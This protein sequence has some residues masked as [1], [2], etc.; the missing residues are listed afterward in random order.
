MQQI[1]VFIHN[2]TNKRF[3]ALGFTVCKP[4]EQTIITFMSLISTLRLEPSENIGT[5]TTTNSSHSE[6]GG[7]WRGGWAVEFVTSTAF[8]ATFSLGERL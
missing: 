3:L 2:N 1:A 7:L 8:T 5:T 6:S 4:L